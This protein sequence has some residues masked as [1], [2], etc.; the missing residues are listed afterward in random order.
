[1][2]HGLRHGG[3]TEMLEK[4]VSVLLVQR[5]GGWRS[6]QVLSKHYAHLSPIRSRKEIDNVF[7]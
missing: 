5:M 2:I 4:G 6:L 3:A 7:E 1:M